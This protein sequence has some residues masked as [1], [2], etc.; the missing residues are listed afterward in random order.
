MTYPIKN[1]SG[2]KSFQYQEYGEHTA[3][4]ALMKYLLMCK[5]YTGFWRM[6]L[7]LLQRVDT[8]NLEK[9]WKSSLPVPSR[10]LFGARLKL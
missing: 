10:L 3:Q 2:K 8:I 6:K 7:Y 1:K 5:C 4:K 9:H